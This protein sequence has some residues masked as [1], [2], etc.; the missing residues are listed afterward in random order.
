MPIA[1]DVLDAA[2]CEPMRTA[3]DQSN[4]DILG[5]LLHGIDVGAAPR[6]A[7]EQLEEALKPIRSKLDIVIGMLA[8]LSYQGVELPARCPIELGERHIA[9]IS[10][11]RLDPGAWLRLRLY[12]D[13]TFREPVVVFAQLGACVADDGAAGQYRNEADLAPIREP[14]L[15]DLGRLA[16]L[17]QRRQWAR[18][19]DMAVRGG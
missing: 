5:F 14:I 3:A 19:P 6:I 8:R 12:F 17:V 13:L 7:D 1:C 4:A 16:L 11:R 2:P 9:W 18:E 15:S 10:D